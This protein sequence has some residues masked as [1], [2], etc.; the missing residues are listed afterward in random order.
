MPVNAQI[1]KTTAKIRSTS[2]NELKVVGRVK[3]IRAT[4]NSKEIKLDAIITEG[5]SDITIIGVNPIKN[6]K[7]FN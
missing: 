3:D 2:D 7:N 4:I 6:P 1:T 5:K